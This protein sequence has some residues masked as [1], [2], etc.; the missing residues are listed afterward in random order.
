MSHEEKLD[1]LK[2]VL[3]F[4]H[5]I[6]GEHLFYCPYCN[7]HNPKLSVNIDKNVYKCW[8]CDTR[9]KDIWRIVRKFGDFRDKRT[10]RSFS[11]EIDYSETN[12]FE[13]LFG[14]KEEEQEEKLTLPEEFIPLSNKKNPISARTALKYLADRGIGKK[15]IINWK[16]GYCSRGEYGGRIVF[17]SFDKSGNVNYFVARTYG[18]DWVKYRNPPATRNV[19]FN[20]L[21]V[22]WKERV[23]LVEGIFDA[24]FLGTNAIPIL[25][26]TMNEDSKLF[27]KIINNDTAVYMALD[28][29]AEKKSMRIIESLISHGIEVYKVDTSGFE[30]I[31]EMPKKTLDKRI[32]SAKMITNEDF[33]S[34]KIRS[35][36]GV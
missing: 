17:P 32:K 10:W 18:D 13:A 34:R 25:G 26:S 14:E 11:E 31:A 24:I 29:D 35:I 3:S 28:D 33:L 1:T 4:S 2:N 16:I 19:I 22:D 7:H 5:R 9:G 21:F 23:F 27:K 12:I 30:D 6:K 8:V 20:E 36:V 15:E